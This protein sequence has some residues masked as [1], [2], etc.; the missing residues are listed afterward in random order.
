MK[1]SLRF[2]LSWSLNSN[3]DLARPQPGPHLTRPHNLSELTVKPPA[4]LETSNFQANL[5]LFY[6]VGD[7]IVSSISFENIILFIIKK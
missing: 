5:K 3:L 7:E 2:E 1:L 6:L 4:E